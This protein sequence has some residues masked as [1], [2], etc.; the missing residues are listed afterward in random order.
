MLD[1]YSGLMSD[2]AN[3]Y[4]KNPEAIVRALCGT[5]TPVKIVDLVYRYLGSDGTL[6]PIE[7]VSEQERKMF[8]E[9]KQIVDSYG[10]ENT[11]PVYT[12]I[13]TIDFLSKN[14]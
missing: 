7:Q 13:Y 14:I 6:K 12:A 5:V 10:L 3:E 4:Q 2:W 9:F 11:L 1:A 8:M